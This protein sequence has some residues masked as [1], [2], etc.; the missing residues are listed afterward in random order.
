MSFL[1]Y[2]AT[3]IEM[4]D[5]VYASCVTSS[6]T[7]ECATRPLL[8]DVWLK[9]EIAEMQMIIWMC[10]V[11]MHITTVI[12]SGMLRWYGHVMRKSDQD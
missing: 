7:Y 4:K 6:M 1:T 12:R 11:S 2:S 3:P 5:R 9:F 8:A 10:D